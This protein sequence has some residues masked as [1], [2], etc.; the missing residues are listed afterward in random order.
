MPVWPRAAAPAPMLMMR[1][2]ARAF[3]CG[4]TAREATSAV[5]RFMANISS[6]VAT[7]PSLTVCQRNPPATFTRTSRPVVAPV[8]CANAAAAARSSVRSTPPT[9]TCGAANSCAAH[10]GIG[11]W[12][13]SPRRA[14]WAWNLRATALPSAPKAPV[15][16]TRCS[17][18][19]TSAP[20]RGSRGGVGLAHTADAAL[21]A[22]LCRGEFEHILEAQQVERIGLAPDAG[23]ALHGIQYRE[24]G[25]RVVQ[26]GARDDARRGENGEHRQL[27]GELRTQVDE[28]VA[29]AHVT[30]HHLADE[31]EAAAAEDVL[32]IMGLTGAQKEVL[33]V[34]LRL[35]RR[36][37]VHLQVVVHQLLVED[38]ADAVGR[39]AAQIRAFEAGDV[40]G[41]KPGVK[42]RIVAPLAGEQ[43][44]RS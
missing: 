17:R 40:A 33:V 31:I 15:I 29:E 7:S 12:S 42:R 21:E 35:E 22:R 27:A 4:I 44:V 6:Q 5:F 39:V 28:D 14:P 36:H 13:I 20:L 25:L 10:G 26:Y 23:T 24:P 3:R 30:R 8:T 43:F 11:A 38:P 18:A 16:T 41:A 9:S 1:P 19:F 2:P 34:V 37:D 32:Q